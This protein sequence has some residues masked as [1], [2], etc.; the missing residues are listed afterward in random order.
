MYLFF[1]IFGYIFTVLSAIIINQ[2][3]NI[4]PI[5]K[6]TKFIHPT[7]NTIFNK[8]STSIIPIILWS[9]IEIIILGTNKCY[10]LGIVLNI[11]L[12]CSISYIIIYGYSL[13]SK[14]ESLVVQIISILVSNFFGYCINYLCLLIGKDTDM[15]ISIISILILTGIYIIIK[16]YPPKSEF[17]RGKI[18]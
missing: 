12:N 1:M 9:F 11:F 15:L 17:F 16:I 8:I 14:E 5:N 18:K 10:I 6:L 13:I 7:E 3:Y 4:F 2:T